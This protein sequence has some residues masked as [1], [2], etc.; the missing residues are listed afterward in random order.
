MIRKRIKKLA[1]PSPHHTITMSGL[2]NKNVLDAWKAH[3][4]KKRTTFLEKVRSKYPDM[5]DDQIA[6]IE[7]MAISNHQ[8]KDGN[9]LQDEVENR[10][11]IPFKRQVHIDDSGIIVASCGKTI[12]DIVF[13]TP[14]VGTHI[15]NYVVG[16]LKITSRERWK[17]D[18][19]V[20][21]HLPKL[22]LYISL[23]ADYPSPD[24][25]HEGP[26]RK[27]VCATPKKKDDRVFKLG[28]E[29]IEATVLAAL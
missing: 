11:K 28:F 16:S 20:Y 12:I 2:T 5:S 14:V 8:S 21:K 13:G 27:L 18:D 22:F 10:L 6:D 1:H 26:T 3:K 7:A 23:A 17:Q 29:D 25:F 4:N 15:S 19:W 24:I 9:L